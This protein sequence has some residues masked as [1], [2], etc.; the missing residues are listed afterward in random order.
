MPKLIVRDVAQ[1]AG[2]PQRTALPVGRSLARLGQ[3]VSQ[4]GGAL[5]AA[6]NERARRRAAEFDVALESEANQIVL[7][8]D[9][10]SRAQKFDEAKSR[11]TE[12]YRPSFITG[13]PVEFDSR[14]GLSSERL[15]NDLRAKTDRDALD[16]ALAD[17][18]YQLE[19]LSNKAATAEN[20]DERSLFLLQG[21][22]AIQES[23]NSGTRS[24]A[25]ADK[26]RQAFYKGIQDAQLLTFSNVDPGMGLEW[27]EA[28]NF[29]G[30]EASKQQW[31]AKL[32]KAN[33]FQMRSELQ[34]EK[35]ERSRLAAENKETARVT[36]SRWIGAANDPEG[37]GVTLAEVE[38]AVKGGFL[39]ETQES[40]WTQI[41]R[42]GG[43]VEPSVQT[44]PRMLADMRR[45][46]RDGT[47]STVIDDAT[48]R[49][50]SGRMSLEE[51][52]SIEKMS[53]ESRFG[54]ALDILEAAVQGTLAFTGSSP[55]AVVAAQQAVVDFTTWE[56][57]HPNATRGEAL[58]EAARL[59]SETDT[60]GMIE[61]T[62]PKQESSRYVRDE[63]DKIMIEETLNQAA[64]D[65]K[66]G[67]MSEED[68][69]ALHLEM[70]EMAEGRKRDAA[71]RARLSG[72]S[73]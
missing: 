55:G 34:A 2:L 61:R 28:G 37:P 27:I 65:L 10:E 60:Y 7:D 50:T 23:L 36:V 22:I 33:V 31:I 12:Q 42:S 11:L 21:E 71:T 67:R 14:T 29:R 39:S 35:A 51:L 46:A 64:A 19:I 25:Q 59:Y 40:T 62:L 53:K 30:T 17:N 72:V 9:L 44:D 48:E 57:E 56:S 3:Q 47:D 49:Y 66:A 41:A 24:Q 8:P 73:E 52:A 1:G 45:R 5:E 32:Q 54:G 26:R 69:I 16:R 4:F 63:T 38:T 68:A 70:D 43:H 20:A 15:L 6:S 58:R 18:E 13:S